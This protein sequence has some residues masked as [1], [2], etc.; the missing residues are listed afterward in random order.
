MR[1]MPVNFSLPTYMFNIRNVFIK[2]IFLIHKLSKTKEKKRIS[3][4]KLELKDI[5]YMCSG[6]LHIKTFKTQ[7]F[8][9][10]PEGLK[11]C[12][13]LIAAQEWVTGKML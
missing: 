6:Y 5:Y 2:A 7:R 12:P 13:F 8:F 9:L 3:S 4:R 10:Q 11:I 1:I